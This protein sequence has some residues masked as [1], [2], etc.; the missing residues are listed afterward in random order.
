MGRPLIYGQ[1]AGP[2]VI[3]DMPIGASEV[4]KNL[5]GKFVKPDG[6][7]RMEIAGAASVNIVGWIEQGERTASATEG[8]DIGGVNVAKD[9]VYEMPACGAAGAA[10]SEATLKAAV[11]ETCDIQMVDTNYQ[12]ADLSA[13]SV[14]ILL[15]VGYRYY[16]SAAGQQ[17]VLVMINWEKVVNTGVA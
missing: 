5:S 7:G 17:S 13:S 15:I 4:F 9:A 14:D 2:Q 3:L 11:G 1:V 12:Y 10:V 16:G 6:S 8:A